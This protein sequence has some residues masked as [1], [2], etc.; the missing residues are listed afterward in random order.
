MP[1]YPVPVVCIQEV[2]LGSLTDAVDVNAGLL[3]VTRFEVDPVRFVT[4][5]AGKEFVVDPDAGFP[6]V[7]VCGEFVVAHD[8]Y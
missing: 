7:P 8:K 2:I 6:V 3:V 1:P 5:E 4:P